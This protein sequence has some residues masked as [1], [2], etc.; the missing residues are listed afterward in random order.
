MPLAPKLPPQFQY[1]V[2]LF[3]CP[4]VA[5]HVRIDHVD[6]ALT[7]LA[8]F[9]LAARTH[10]FIELLGNA[11]PLLGL[12]TTY[13][14]GACRLDGLCSHFLGYSFEYLGLTRRPGRFLPLD[15][16]NEEPPLLTLERGASRHQVSHRLPVR[17]REVLHQGVSL[18][19]HVEYYVLQ[20][21]RLILFPLGARCYLCVVACCACTVAGSMA[22][23]VAHGALWVVA[24]SRAILLSRALLF[25]AEH[26]VVL[27]VDTISLALID[28]AT[29]IEQIVA[30]L[31]CN[32]VLL[33]ELP[34]PGCVLITAVR[35]G[36]HII[37]RVGDSLVLPAVLLIVIETV[38][39]V[40]CRIILIVVILRRGGVH[41][42]LHLLAEGL[43][44]TRLG[45]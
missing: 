40:T 45:R 12:A 9:A 19:G 17:V 7:A 22:S 10:R 2:L 28:N 20:E 38:I 18:V 25:L 30:I 23:L 15:I 13:V 3:D 32:H 44:A 35:C 5:P 21:H 36:R 26:L 24:S 34:L 42:E 31:E 43:K 6:P 39:R 14:L 1:V 29:L 37:L 33:L 27:R 41:L 11:R 8:G 4:F 16:L